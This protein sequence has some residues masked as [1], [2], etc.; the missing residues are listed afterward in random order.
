MKIFIL[1]IAIFALLAGFSETSSIPD[2]TKFVWHG[3]GGMRLGKP[4]NIDQ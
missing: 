4:D 2:V 3:A 1:I